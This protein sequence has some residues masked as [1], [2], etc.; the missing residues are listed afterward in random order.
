MIKDVT[1]EDNGSYQCRAKND[2]DTLDAVAVV[3]VEGT[4][5][6]YMHAHK[7]A[8]PRANIYNKGG[9]IRSA[10]YVEFLIILFGSAAEVHKA[11]AGQG[12]ERAP[13]SGIRV[14]DLR[15]AD[16]R[17]NLAEERRAHQAQRLLAAHQW[18]SELG[19]FCV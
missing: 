10:V 5:Y 9:L 4:L 16:A 2:I 19:I 6:T 7:G 14:R 1:E 15:E 17:D 13:G 11:T 12:G 18:V 3:V 8:S